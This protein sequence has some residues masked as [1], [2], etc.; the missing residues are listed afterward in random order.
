MSRPVKWPKES[1]TYVNIRLPVE[2]DTLINL[3]WHALASR[4]PNNAIFK[5][6]VIRYGLLH[7]C[8]CNQHLLNIDF[9]EAKEKILKE[10]VK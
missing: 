2:L 9:K 6:D 1:Y 10:L 8:E 5:A 3:L 7:Y 4:H